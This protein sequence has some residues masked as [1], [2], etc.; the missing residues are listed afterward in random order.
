M[1]RVNYPHYRFLY[2]LSI[3]SVL[4]CTLLLPTEVVSGVP[5][6]V[7][8]GVTSGPTFVDDINGLDFKVG[9]G[10]TYEFL[11]EAR[12]TGSVQTGGTVGF[13]VYSPDGADANLVHSVTMGPDWGG[14]TY[15]DLPSGLLT[16]DLDGTLPEQILTG[17]ATIAKG[18]NAPDFIEVITFSIDINDSG[19]ICIDSAFYPPAG[20]WTMSP[21]GPP[22]WTAGSGDANV[23]GSRT[24]A[25]CMTAFTLPCIPLD[26]NYPTAASG[27][28]CNPIII[29]GSLGD[30]DPGPER[31]SGAC[32]NLVPSGTN[33]DTGYSVTTD[34][35][36]VA[37]VANDGTITYLPSPQ[38]VN[39]GVTIT[40]TYTEAGGQASDCLIDVTVTNVAPILTCPPDIGYSGKVGTV[41]TPPAQALDLDACD[42]HVYSLVSVTPSPVGSITVDPA[43]GAVTFDKSIG[44]EGEQHTDYEVCLEVSD[45]IETDTCCFTLTYIPIEPFCVTIDEQ[46][47][48]Q[49]HHQQLCISYDAGSNIVGGFDFLITY[50]ASALSLAGAY[51][52]NIYPDYKWEYFT[53]RY[54][55]SGN[56]SGGCPSGL[57]RIV[58]LAE[59]NNG[60]AH[61]ISAPLVPGDVFACLDFLV[62]NDRNFECNFFPVRWFW[63]DCGDNTM[64]S[65]HGDTLYMSQRVLDY[66]GTDQGAVLDGF[67]AD[68][69]GGD[70]TLPTLTGA[71]DQ[72]DVSTEKGAPIRL[73]DFKN[74]GVFAICADSIDARGDVNLN[75]LSN[76]IADAVMFTEYYITGLA[77]FG[78][79][80]EGSIAATEINADGIPLTVADLVYLIRIIVGDALPIPKLVHNA[81]KAMFAHSV[82][83]SDGI[84][85]TDRELG[86]AL[87]VFDGAVDVELLASGVELKV[88][89]V[90]G[91]TQA[92][93]YHIGQNSI[94]PG[95]VISA[96]AAPA[97]VEA[98]DYSGVALESVIAG[99]PTGFELR[100][101]YPNPFNPKTTLHFTTPRQTDWRVRIYNVAGQLVET[102]SG[103]SESGEVRVGWSA[104]DYPSG[105]YLAKVIAG[106]QSATQKLLLL[107]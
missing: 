26:C 13:I 15:W 64:S 46:Q 90:D 17:G 34:G 14:T 2:T 92:L 41:T 93:V 99:Q 43:T 1:R 61:P 97:R 23:G 60:D 38:D 75:G 85:S 101:A 95:A 59:T 76:E 106:S 27:D 98:A 45:G 68:I 28:H 6:D 62:T 49:G 51:E 82:A 83:D 35:A 63:N 42:S 21:D 39:V 50:D 89:L 96:S 33:P 32:S 100:G 86:A 78:S 70:L 30:P 84:I 52:G 79:H 103:R 47:T 48:L 10:Y 80:I 65:V 40:V 54:G 66:T 91:N 104:D 25:L 88:G 3:F 8:M 73:I 107:K 81:E 4:A 18:F 55:A 71:P 94:A 53:Y 58:G 22:S 5:A 74:G 67:R 19:T 24:D 9:L 7:R 20:D 56:C 57:V 29:A 72:C 16:L 102:L 69:T 77:A 11:V 31:S 44:T 37:T 12:A 87:F 105:L 36:G